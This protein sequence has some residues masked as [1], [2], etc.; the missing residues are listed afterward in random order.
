MHRAAKPWIARA[1][2]L[3]LQSHQ[4]TEW[5][6]L[7][8]LKSSMALETNPDHLRDQRIIPVEGAAPKSTLEEQSYE[9]KQLAKALEIHHSASECVW[10]SQ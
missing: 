3:N 5:L 4:G 1:I 9:T 2:E 10:S 6:H 8:I 7:A